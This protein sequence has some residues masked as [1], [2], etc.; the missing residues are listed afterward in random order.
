MGR[1]PNILHS[2]LLSEMCED[3]NLTDPFRFLY[4]DRREYTYKPRTVNARNRSRLDFFLISDNLLDHISNCQI[5]PNLQNKL[6]DHKAVTITLNENRQKNTGTGRP[7]ISNKDLDDDLLVF[8]VHAT[9][10]ETYLI[11]SNTE[12]YGRTSKL[13]LLTICG[14]IKHL[15]REC[16]P[17]IRLLVGNECSEENIR[18][19]AQKIVRLQ[20]LQAYLNLNQIEGSNLNCEPDI[21][22]ESLLLNI[23]NETVSHQVFMRKKRLK[24]LHG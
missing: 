11:H 8:L 24:K 23:K 10:A 1:P 4:P 20:I 15:I 19:R 13:E 9:V 18:S 22:L 21:F 16:G 12:L 6:F 5:S 7:T 14:R 17:E 3:L 2:N